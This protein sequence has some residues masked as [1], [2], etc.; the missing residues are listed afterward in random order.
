MGS[1]KQIAKAEKFVPRLDRVLL[2]LVPVT[3]DQVAPY[4]GVAV[5]HT[6]ATQ[7]SVDEVRAGRHTYWSFTPVTTAAWTERRGDDGQGRHQVPAV[8]RGVPGPVV[9]AEGLRRRG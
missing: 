4:D 9:P 8:V 3:P 6:Q 5:E 2:T 1:P 7:Q